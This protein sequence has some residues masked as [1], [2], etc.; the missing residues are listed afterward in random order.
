M[1]IRETSAP[2][3]ECRVGPV[4]GPLA[5]ASGPST[6]DGPTLECVVSARTD[7]LVE[8]AGDPPACLLDTAGEIIQNSPTLNPMKKYLVEFIGTFFLVFTVGAA[9]RSGAA[10]APVA[11]VR[12]SW[13]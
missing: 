3:S 4:A 1:N 2:F 7:P 6:S 10:L 9:V 13:S 8:R 11:S 12:F 5:S